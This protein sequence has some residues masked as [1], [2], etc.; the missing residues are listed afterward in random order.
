MQRKFE[1]HLA[2]LLVFMVMLFSNTLFAQKG[3]GFDALRNN[4][5]TKA[6]SIF[7][8]QA[9]S[10]KKKLHGE[11]GLV[12]LYSHQD[13]PDQNLA[14]AFGHLNKVVKIYNSLN[15]KKKNKQKPT[16]GLTSKILKAEKKQIFEQLLVA[17]EEKSDLDFYDAILKNRLAYKEKKI[18]YG[19]RGKCIVE[20]SAQAKNYADLSAFLAPYYKGLRK[21][22]ISDLKKIERRIF[23]YFLAEN[24]WE[25]INQ[26][27]KEQPRNFVNND[28]GLKYFLGIKD[29]DD[30]EAFAIFIEEHP[31]SIFVNMATD[32]ICIDEYHQVKDSKKIDKYINFISEYSRSRFSDSIEA[33]LVEVIETDGSL[34]QYQ[35]L[36]E[37]YPMLTKSTKFMEGLYVAYVM[38]S[39]LVSL[40]QF[41][42]K[43][44]NFHDKNKLKKDRE[45]FRLRDIEEA[46]KPYPQ[47]MAEKAKRTIFREAR[48]NPERAFASLQEFIADDVDKKDWASA[49]KKVEE[50]KTVFGKHRFY[51]SLVEILNSPDQGIKAESVGDAVNS[52]GGEYVPIISADGK[53]MFFCAQGRPNNKGREDI[54]ISKKVNNEWQKAELLNGINTSSNNEAPLSISA[55]GNRLI[56]FDSGDLAY[57]KKTSEGWSDIEHFSKNINSGSWQADAMVTADGKQMIFVKSKGW[58]GMDIYVSKKE[59]DGSWGKAFS[60]GD[61]I[62]TDETE[63]SP[64]LHPDM[65]TLYFCSEGHGGLGGLDVFRS[66][67]LDDT[68][69]NWSEPVNLGKE[70]NS[71]SKEWGYQISTDGT[72]AYFSS[73]M[74]GNQ[75]IFEVSLPIDLRPDPVKTVSGTI[76]GLPKNQSAKIIVKDEKTGKEIAEATT[77]PVTGEYFVVI[78]EGI[79]PVISIEEDDIYSLP[80]TIVMTGKGADVKQNLKVT[81]FK[82]DNVSLAF[83]NVLFDTDQSNI[84]ADFKND[85]DELVAI[86]QKN[87]FEITI[88]GHTDNAGSDDHNIKLSQQRAEAVKA[89]LVSKGCNAKNI[90]FNLR[91][92][93][94]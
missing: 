64:F 19:L 56:V 45:I 88:E 67:R 5:F 92:L 26:F 13:Y 48:T 40:E 27:K 2:T 73:A 30:I 60:I 55:D 28:V 18:I 50:Y 14:F 72:K 80:E 11:L 35:N 47:R 63:R 7:E 84:K 1:L 36:I 69:T 58:V 68:W 93:R 81:S 10:K 39:T 75:D 57:S 42:K 71:T 34:N 79:T 94:F 53:S 43:Y 54:F 76:D 16:L 89:Y 38:D 52:K 44:P 46:K 37:M 66:T 24:G 20:K 77:N 8:K 4:N 62:N 31:Q 6:K 70:I 9:K 3:E 78:P 22:S 29:K 49:I 65:K 83:N 74:S 85:L 90:P 15:Q 32:S 41:E 17:A 33:S 51:L 82:D 25:K 61:V 21:Q 91:P 87:Q 23:D 86:V 59:K 12:K